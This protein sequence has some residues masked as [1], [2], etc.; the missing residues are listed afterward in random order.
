MT[1]LQTTSGKTCSTTFHRDTLA[2]VRLLET[3]EDLA[4]VAP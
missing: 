2:I 1:T 4:R 3:F